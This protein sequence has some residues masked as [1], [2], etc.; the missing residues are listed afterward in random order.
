M[1]KDA[2]I[3]KQTTK[4][5]SKNKIMDT[6]I[7]KW[8]KHLSMQSPRAVERSEFPQDDQWIAENKTFS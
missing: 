6:C 5:G 3:L 1:N 4:E 2:Q 7:I 8:R